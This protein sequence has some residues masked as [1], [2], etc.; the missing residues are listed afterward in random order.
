MFAGQ[1]RARKTDEHQTFKRRDNSRQ[2]RQLCS[3]GE[4]RCRSKQRV[5]LRFGS[6]IRGLLF[7]NRVHIGHRS[8]RR[9]LPFLF[10][11]AQLLAATRLLGKQHPCA[12]GSVTTLAHMLERCRFALRPGLFGASK[13]KLKVRTADYRPAQGLLRV[14]VA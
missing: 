2:L 11:D 6:R 1:H 5:L 8:Y 14:R 3:S 13:E 10:L 7:L 12:F 4:M 9:G